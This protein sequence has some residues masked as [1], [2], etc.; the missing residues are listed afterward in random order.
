M[1]KLI[2]IICFPFKILGL[3]LIYFY[4]FIISPLLPKTCRFFPTCSTYAI[5]AIK[6]FGIIVGIYLSV[7]RIIRCNPKSI[8]GFDFIPFNMKGEE[9]WLL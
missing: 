4:K 1:T 9:K 8:G 5:Q 6:H 7:K 3:G 2:N